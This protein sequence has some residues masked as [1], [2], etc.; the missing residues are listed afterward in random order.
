MSTM[1]TQ[2]QTSAFDSAEKQPTHSLFDKAAKILSLWKQRAK[3][4]HHLSE[5]PDYLLRDIGMDRYEQYKECNKPFW[6]G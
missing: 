4:R 2:I 1:V 3:T 6:Q 5:L